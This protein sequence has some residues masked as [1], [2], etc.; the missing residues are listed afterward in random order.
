MRYYLLGISGTAMASLAVLLKQRGHQVWGSDE[1]IYPPMSEFLK[2]HQIPVWRGYS[3]SH[4]KTEF[5]IAVIGNAL[6][7]G[8]IEIETILNDRLPFASLPEIIRKEFIDNHCNIVVTGTH[9]KT[10]TTALMSWILEYAGLDPS[11]LIGGIAKN[12]DSSIRSGGGKFFVI[13]GDEYDC[14]FFD[15]RPKFLHY[16]PDYLIINNI[17]FDHA[18]IYPNLEA[19]KN[20]FQKLLRIIPQKGLVVANSESVAVQ[21][22]L[23]P[24]YSRLQTIGR[25]HANDWS[26]QVLNSDNH[27]NLFEVFQSGGS[28]GKFSFPFSGEYQ[29]QNVLAVVAVARDMGIEWEIIKAALGQFKGVKRRLEY[30]GNFQGTDVYDDFAHHP[31]SIK[32]TLQALKGRF[33]NRRLVALFEP[34]TNTM[35]RKFFQSDLVEAFAAADVILITPIHRQERLPQNDRL[36][37]PQLATDLKELQKRVIPMQNYSDILKILKNTLR[38]DDI[39]VLLTNGS[40]GGEYEKLYQRIESS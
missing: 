31:T 29:I 10:T 35:V 37:I 9:G 32:S 26:Y 19:I 24:L 1:G 28:A 40:L 15:K 13:E 34:R 22:V 7:R 4:L 14:A 18:D 25:N 11:F 21:E 16:F 27:K 3:K 17:E 2:E 12:F 20:A 33:P 30:W 36:S 5:D 6:S 23:Y 39:L 8:N 38:K